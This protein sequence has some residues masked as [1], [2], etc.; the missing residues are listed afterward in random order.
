MGTRGDKS[1]K[2]S[3]NRPQLC[4]PLFN[5]VII[6]LAYNQL[7]NSVEPD[8]MPNFV[9]SNHGLHCLPVIQ[10]FLDTW[11]IWKQ[12]AIKPS[13]D[14]MDEEIK[15]HLLNELSADYM[16]VIYS[17]NYTEMMMIYWCFRSLSTLL[18]SYWVNEGV[19]MTGSVK[20]C[21]SHELH[22]IYSGI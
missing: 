10:E 18:K 1:G 15:C 16:G 3:L 11:G 22:S 17:L 7:P 14:F 9:A 4:I 12:L 13:A 19:T 6:W 5:T 8:Q 2:Q 20:W 21:T